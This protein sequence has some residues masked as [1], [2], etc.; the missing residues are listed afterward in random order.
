MWS[1]FFLSPKWIS[2]VNL[3]IFSAIFGQNEINSKIR[4]MGGLDLQ[5]IRSS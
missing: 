5:K 2:T 4:C 3:I 1:W